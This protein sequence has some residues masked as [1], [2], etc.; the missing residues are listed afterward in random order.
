MKIKSIV[1]MDDNEQE[2]IY[3]P[4]DLIILALCENKNNPTQPFVISQ[5][6]SNSSMQLALLKAIVKE[7]NQ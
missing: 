2:I 7:E 4:Q 3:T 6:S 5:M 1:I